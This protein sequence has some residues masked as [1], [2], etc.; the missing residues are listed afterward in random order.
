MIRSRRALVIL[1]NARVYWKL[2]FAEADPALLEQTSFRV[3]ERHRG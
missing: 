1:V 2:V 3:Q